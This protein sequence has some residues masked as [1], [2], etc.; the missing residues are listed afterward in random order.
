MIFLDGSSY[1]TRTHT[2][3]LTVLRATDY[4]NE[5]Y[6]VGMAGLEPTIS[7]SQ[8][9]CLTKLD[10]IPILGRPAEPLNR[11]PHMQ[12]TTNFASS[13]IFPQS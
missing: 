12:I 11:Q 1:G 8:A 9:E 13:G 7:R 3:R 10:H 2:T 6:L 4:T 5:E